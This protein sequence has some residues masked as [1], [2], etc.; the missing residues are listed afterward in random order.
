MGGR[1]IQGKIRGV[2][3]LYKAGARGGE[4]SSSKRSVSVTSL[5]RS[6][7]ENLT[8]H[9]TLVSTYAHVRIHART[10][11]RTHVR[12]H[13]RT[14]T[15]THTHIYDAVLVAARED[16][17]RRK[18]HARIPGVFDHVSGAKRA[19]VRNEKNKKVP[20]SKFLFSRTTLKRA[21]GERKPHGDEVETRL[22]L[23]VVVVIVVIV[24]V[25]VVVNTVGRGEVFDTRAK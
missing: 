9:G 11:A 25:L 4:L 3:V 5:R 19:A 20:V 12:T 13:T 17:T 1:D 2:G 24:V 15:H 7:D 18:D 6:F 8:E 23:V 16:A 10:H 21:L 14:H 22:V